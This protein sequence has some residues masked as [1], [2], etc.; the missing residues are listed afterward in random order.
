M[1]M[2][3]NSSPSDVEEELPVLLPAAEQPSGLLGGQKE[4]KR[5]SEL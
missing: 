1:A 2:S 4:R 5:S 3:S